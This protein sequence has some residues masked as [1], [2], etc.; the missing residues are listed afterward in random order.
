MDDIW[1][2][3]RSHQ[4]SPCTPS[5]G[6]H[7]RPHSIVHSTR[8]WSIGDEE[9]YVVDIVCAKESRVRDFG[10]SLISQYLG[11]LFSLHLLNDL[12]APIVC[13][14]RVLMS[15]HIISYHLISYH[16]TPLRCASLPW[17]WYEAA[18]SIEEERIGLF[19]ID[20]HYCLVL[21]VSQ[22]GQDWLTNRLTDWLVKVMVVGSVVECRNVIATTSNY[23][24]F[25][26]TVKSQ[27]PPLRSSFSISHRPNFQQKG[28]LVKCFVCHVRPSVHK[29]PLCSSSTWSWVNL[30]CLHFSPPLFCCNLLERSWLTPP[31]TAVGSILILLIPFPP[32]HSRNTQWRWR[33]MEYY[34]KC[35][36][37]QRLNGY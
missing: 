16:V 19:Y 17:F 29:N 25:L 22:C 4:S 21:T 14:V 1:N 26:W 37:S 9:L 8:L 36:K 20:M 3:T 6:I 10:R 23:R 12:L 15:Y 34:I 18:M 13:V 32:R 5:F 30:L 31:F 24:L 28:A 2:P 11:T 7:W 27:P 35:L 33:T